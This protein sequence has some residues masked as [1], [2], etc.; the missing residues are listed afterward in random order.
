MPTFRKFSHN[1][2]PLPLADVR[3]CMAYYRMLRKE[4]HNSAHV[5]FA[6]GPMHIA[7]ARAQTVCVRQRNIYRCMF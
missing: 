6:Y 7:I 2:G 3:Y 4:G 5:N 1:G